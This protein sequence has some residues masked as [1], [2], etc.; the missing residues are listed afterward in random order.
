[1]KSGDAERG[2]I[3]S[4]TAVFAAVDS[5]PTATLTRFID[6]HRNR[7]GVEPICRAMA[8]AVATDYAAK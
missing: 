7:F 2:L 8:I 3:E 6:T 5:T 1:M 4:T